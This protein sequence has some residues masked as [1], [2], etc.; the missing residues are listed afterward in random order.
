MRTIE[1]TFVDCVYCEKSFENNQKNE[2]FLH[3]FQCNT[4]ID[5]WKKCSKK[6][7]LKIQNLT[8]HVI[9]FGSGNLNTKEIVKIVD[10][11]KLQYLIYRAYKDSK[12]IDIDEI[13]QLY[14]K[15]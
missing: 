4:F 11:T 5:T 7:S 2:K 13:C 12:D 15:L 1:P 10:L 9:C 14:K 8:P 3:F 6:L